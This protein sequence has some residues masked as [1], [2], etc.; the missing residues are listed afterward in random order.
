MKRAGSFKR[1]GSSL[2][3]LTDFFLQMSF[4]LYFVNVKLP[5]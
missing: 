5:S 2:F 1:T 4:Y 3:L